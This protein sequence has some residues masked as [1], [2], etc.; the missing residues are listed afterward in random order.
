MI[1]SLFRSLVA[2]I[3]PAMLL[4]R[5]LAEVTVPDPGTY[6]VDRAGIV[7]AQQENLL[8]GWLRELEQKTTAQVK[9]LTVSSL[10]GEDVS[11]F[12]QRHAERW[13][14]GRSGKDN[15]ALIV[16][17]PKSA[18][19]RGEVRIHTGYGLEAIMPDSWAGSLSRKVRDEYFKEG[20]YSEGIYTLTVTVAN[21]VAEAANTQLS[22][23]PVLRHSRRGGRGVDA[24]GLVCGGLVPLLIIVLIISSLGRRRYHR[25]WGGGGVWE[26]IIL[27]Q[28]L[29]RLAG[30]G[31]RWG[32]GGFGSGFG[33][34]FGGGFGGSFGG[35]GHFGGGGGGASW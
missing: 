17:V 25:R 9:V 1:G 15:G 16:V 18:G 34:G 26:A 13:K 8:E 23:M 2:F 31:R 19:Q 7:D 24:G 14:L 27:G 4:P 12:A 33:R 3:L 6:I 21:T 35:G 20:R 11:S 22:G 10:E 28:L 32:G 29:S 30:G 5:A